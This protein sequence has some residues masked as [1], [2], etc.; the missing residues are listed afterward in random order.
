MADETAELAARAVAA[1]VAQGLRLSTAE[2]DTGGGIGAALIDVPGVSAVFPGGATVSAN[3]PKGSIL[4]VPEALLRA[5]GA[6]SEE[7]V[8]A[9]AEGARRVFGTEIAIAES[10]ITGPGGGSAERP[11]GLVWI[12]IVGPGDRRVVEQHVWESDRAGNKMATVRRALAM[13][14]EAATAA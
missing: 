1:L 3:A 14:I 9:M 4:G 5:H 7:A 13:V 12:A 6:V 10:G 2:T 11:V 8:L